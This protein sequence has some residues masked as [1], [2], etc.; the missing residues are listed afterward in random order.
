MFPS[1]PGI[2][3]VHLGRKALAYSVI[4]LALLSQKLKVV[5]AKWCE[6][7]LVSPR[8]RV[9]VGFGGWWGVVFLWK[10]REKGKGAGKVGRLSKLP[11]TKCLPSGPILWLIS[12][13][14]SPPNASPPKKRRVFPFVEPLKSL[15]KKR[16]MHK[17]NKE[18][19]KTTKKKGN[20]KSKLDR[21]QFFHSRQ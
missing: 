14:P 1:L 19:R 9:G 21:G 7:L 8:R 11:F 2:S 17:K 10:M 15:E 13:F 6:F 18:N 16:K 5:F 4:F 3:G 12:K 20:R